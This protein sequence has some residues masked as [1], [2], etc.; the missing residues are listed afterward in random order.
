MAQTESFFIRS[1]KQ[2]I[3]MFAPNPVRYTLLSRVGQTRRV[4]NVSLT[5]QQH[6]RHVNYIARREVDRVNL[7]RRMSLVY[8]NQFFAYNLSTGATERIS[9]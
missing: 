5:P 7:A 8:G 9:L 3:V 2:A 6:L 1:L 4:I